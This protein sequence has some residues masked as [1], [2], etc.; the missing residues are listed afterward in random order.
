MFYRPGGRPV[1]N[2]VTPDISM[3]NIQIRLPGLPVTICLRPDYETNKEENRRTRKEKKNIYV[4][5]FLYK[6]VK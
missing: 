6:R 1:P 5:V 4:I 2:S 3:Q